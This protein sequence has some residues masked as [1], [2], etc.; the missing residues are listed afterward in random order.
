MEIHGKVLKQT[1]YGK[2]IYYDN[3]LIM[4]K[5]NPQLN[6]WTNWDYWVDRISKDKDFNP[7]IFHKGITWR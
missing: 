1:C 3:I 2:G 6:E 4:D 7:K 5:S